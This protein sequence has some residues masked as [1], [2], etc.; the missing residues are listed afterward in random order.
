MRKPYSKKL[1]KSVIDLMLPP[2]RLTV[3]AV[4]EKTG[5]SYST[6]HLWRK[7]YRQQNPQGTG[8]VTKRR[9]SQK[10]KIKALAL[11]LPPKNLTI[12]TTSDQT[13]VEASTL[14]HW[15]KESGLTFKSAFR[16]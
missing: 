16:N 2:H 10:I 4:A 13:G 11:M 1:I 12:E 7:E 15:R 6:L 5:I 14:R 9:Y 8:L 3:K